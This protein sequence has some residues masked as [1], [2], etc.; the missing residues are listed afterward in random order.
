MTRKHIKRMVF[1]NL[2]RVVSIFYLSVLAVTATSGKLIAQ[3]LTFAPIFNDG[4]I[5]QCEM[6]VN[7]WGNAIPGSTV[8][9]LLDGTKVSTATTDDGGRWMAVMPAREAGG[10][11]VLSIK[12]GR[13]QHAISDVY[14]G[15]VWLATGQSNMVQPLRNAEG[16][17]ERLKQ[18]MA[19]IRFVK[20]P[21]KTGLPVDYKMTSE[22]L[23][24]KTFAPPQNSEIAAVAF[25]FA[26]HIQEA[27]ERKIGIIQSS[28]GGT[29][30]QAWTPLDALDAHQELIHYADQVRLGL[31]GSR[32][33]DDFLRE[34]ERANAYNTA[35]REWRVHREGPPPEN[36]GTL[37]SENPY[38][39][40]APTVLYENM[41]RPL[42]PY[43]A[44]GVI[45]YQGEG[46][47]SNPDEYRILFPAMI[48]AWRKAWDRPEWPFFF[49]QLAAYN[50]P[51]ADW[52]GLRA[53]QAYTR[54]VLPHTGMALAVDA[55]EKDDIHPRYK[56]PVGERLARLALNQVYGQ[57]VACR[58]PHIK[59]AVTQVDQVV[60][61][62][63]FTE[64]GLQ[65]SNGSSNIPGFELAGTDGVFHPAS[66]HI[67]SQTTV[68]VTCEKVKNPV[69]LRYAWANWIEPEVTLV[70]S[71]GLPAEPFHE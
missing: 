61:C 54:D 16:G 63:D 67:R 40:R 36:P 57:E 60:V 70:N 59:Q 7:I 39:Q 5:L 38:S 66:A 55:G 11:F 35:F 44:R 33:K 25:F 6:P 31:S 28:Y 4:A 56:Q 37:S 24:W 15:E 51:S 12:S 62:F 21:Q 52:P 32:T 30:A 23:V 22:D 18:T 9:V 42:I 27:I 13:R 10:P 68:V 58:G 49:V 26:E 65:T 50:H 19:D 20:V 71:E 17:P 1:Y 3:Q 48:N 64:Q 43:T 46:N 34:I 69:S 29:P 8:D 2:L 47:S 41:I 45:W 53:A 14:F